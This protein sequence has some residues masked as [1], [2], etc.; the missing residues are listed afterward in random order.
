M[1]EGAAFAVPVVD[2]DGV[3]IGQTPMILMVLGEKFGLAGARPQE[4]A[5]VLQALGDMNDLFNE[6]GKFVEN[7]ERKD[8]WFGYLEGKLEGR[9]WMG[10]T[11]EPSIADFH[12]V[13]AMEWINKKKIDYSK[14]PRVT[15]WWA[16]LQA[17]PVVKKMHDSCVDG[18][19]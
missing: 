1:P 2:V 11:A 9:A 14:F 15:K 17:V 6:H 5:Q 19:S 16:D 18:R 7:E 12:G 10:G 13:F 8:K 3:S 4:K